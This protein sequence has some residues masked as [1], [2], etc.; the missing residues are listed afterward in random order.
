MLIGDCVCVVLECVVCSRIALRAI[1]SSEEETLFFPVM[2]VSAEEEEEVVARYLLHSLRP[3]SQAGVGGKWH[4]SP[5][6]VSRARVQVDKTGRLL[7]RQTLAAH[8]TS[9]CCQKQA[10][11]QGVQWLGTRDEGMLRRLLIKCWGPEPAI[12][13]FLSQRKQ[14]LTFPPL[15]EVRMASSLADW[16]PRASA[17]KAAAGAGEAKRALAAAA[18]L[19]KQALVNLHQDFHCH[20]FPSLFWSRNS[21]AAYARLMGW[22]RESAGREWEER[23]LRAMLPVGQAIITFEEFVTTI[24]CMSPHTLHGGR[25]GFFRMQR[26]FRAYDVERRD[27]LSQQDMRRMRGDI[28]RAKRHESPS[29]ESLSQAVKQD[30]AALPLPL[31]P[32]SGS[33]TRVTLL[34]LLSAFARKREA[35][36]GLRGFSLLMRIYGLDYTKKR[37]YLAAGRASRRATCPAHSV[38]PHSIAAHVLVL[39]RSAARVEAKAESVRVKVPTRMRKESEER[40]SASHVGRRTLALVHSLAQRI[41]ESPD[42]LTKRTC[43]VY[44]NDSDW[45]RVPEQEFKSRLQLLSELL[46]RAKQVLLAQSRVPK[47]ASPCLVFGDV[48][49]NLSDLLSYEGL[50]WPWL[51]VEVGAR[52]VF[53]GDFVDRGRQSL[54]TL[55]YLLALK[56]LWP[57]RVTLL[58]GNHETRAMQAKYGFLAECERKL[59][60]SG[61]RVHAAQMG[62]RAINACVCDCLPICGLVDES[63]FSCHGGIPLTE[64]RIAHLVTMPVPLVSPDEQFRPAMEILWSD[65]VEE[66]V[67]QQMR[68]MITGSADSTTTE[69]RSFLPNV[70]RSTGNFFDEHAVSRFNQV[71]GTS[72]VLRAHEQQSRGFKLSLGGSVVT[73]FSSSDYEKHGNTAALLLIQ[74]GDILPVQMTT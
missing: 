44:S 18:R 58:R 9:A 71:N 14:R 8:L 36:A 43:S 24:A 47:T 51:Q 37:A 11:K 4:S 63:L 1:V 22:S 65:P 38:Q 59:T 60:H 73:V 74:D 27:S 17:S 61:G 46:S 32:Q 33:E 25:N 70:K 29:E 5:E 26:I 16:L 55:L 48:H 50:W 7:S 6:A 41:R 52:L 42:G 12:F 66:Q 56:V 53:L 68:H 69:Q 45:S 3:E 64:Q 19:S 72:H 20:A 23:L 13:A 49:G 30:Y 10:W 57:S 2:K 31:S 62:W 34:Q 15:V 35:G 54:E 67:M 40:M 21:L 39:K 28:L